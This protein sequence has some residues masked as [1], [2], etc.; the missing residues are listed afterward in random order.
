MK[1][2]IWKKEGMEKRHMS[3]IHNELKLGI[4]AVVT[5]SSLIVEMAPD[6]ILMFTG[7]ASPIYISLHAS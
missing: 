4:C 5:C 6:E 7:M 2:L 3:L 1:I